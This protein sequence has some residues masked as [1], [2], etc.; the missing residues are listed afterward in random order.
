MPDETPVDSVLLTK[1]Y[2]II[3]YL[4]WKSACGSYEERVSELNEKGL[5]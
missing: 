1:L 3:T 5:K 2:E 4:S